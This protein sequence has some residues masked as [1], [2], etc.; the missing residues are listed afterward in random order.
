MVSKLEE[1]VAAMQAD[2]A[3]R[4]AWLRSNYLPDPLPEVVKDCLEKLERRYDMLREM[5]E[6]QEATAAFQQTRGQETVPDEVVSRLL[7]GE[8][9]IRVWREYRHLSLRTLASQVGISPSVLSD[10]ETGKSEGR[11]VTLRKI[12]RHLNVST[13]EL[14]QSAGRSAAGTSAEGGV[15]APPLRE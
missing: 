15:A 4:M 7:A 12:A 2:F 1:E 6:D 5:L 13:D 14:L 9:P 10:M 3:G 8:N 11:P